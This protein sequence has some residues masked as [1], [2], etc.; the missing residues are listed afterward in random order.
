MS[1]GDNLSYWFNT[2]L[3]GW[4]IYDNKGVYMFKDHRLWMFHKGSRYSF[5]GW[6]HV[7]SKIRMTGK[8]CGRHYFYGQTKCFK[9]T[10]YGY[11]F[12]HF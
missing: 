8:H 3:D 12:N 9:R 2:P 7:K 6:E 11:R 10:A 5:G 1:W 4:S